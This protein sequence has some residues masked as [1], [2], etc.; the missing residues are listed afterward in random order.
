MAQTEP[1]P[2]AKPVTPE[3][4]KAA[5][6]AEAARLREEAETARRLGGTLDQQGQFVDPDN[7]AEK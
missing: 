4:K 6:A 7:K 3:H 5:E 2:E 1:D